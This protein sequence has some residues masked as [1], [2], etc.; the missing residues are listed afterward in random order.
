MLTGYI[1]RFLIFLT[2]VNAIPFIF[3]IAYLTIVPQQELTESDQSLEQNVAFTQLFSMTPNPTTWAVVMSMV[4]TLVSLMYAV[5]MS[6]G[7]YSKITEYIFA[8]ILLIITIPTS[9]ALYSIVQYMQT[10]GYQGALMRFRELIPY[11]RSPLIFELSRVGTIM[12]IVT[13]VGLS[14]YLF[15]RSPA[16]IIQQVA[17]KRRVR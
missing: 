2:V 7:I 14:S 3:W 15:I 8:T 4:L 11:I 1:P 12:S 16:D 5:V 9:I 10:D 6:R 13:F 17:G